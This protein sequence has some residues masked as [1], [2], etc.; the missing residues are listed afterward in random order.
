MT[1]GAH[2]YVKRFFQGL[3]SRLGSPSSPGKLV[4]QEA[5]LKPLELLGWPYGSHTKG[6]ATSPKPPPA[7]RRKVNQPC[8]GTIVRPRFLR[9]YQD[10][11]SASLKERDLGPCRYVTPSFFSPPIHG[12]GDELEGRGQS[13]K[14]PQKPR[15]V[16]FYC[17]FMPKG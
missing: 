3:A 17:I 14:M 5:L 7:F 13:G 9:L 15:K 4:Q 16:P 12:R 6:Q 11:G 2:P 1:S 10:V 8:L